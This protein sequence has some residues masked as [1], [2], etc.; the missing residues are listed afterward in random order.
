MAGQ[1]KHLMYDHTL[2]TLVKILQGILAGLLVL[3]LLTIRVWTGE[4]GS[5]EL[6]M[7]FERTDVFF[8]S[9]ENIVRRKIDYLQNKELFERGGSFDDTRAV[10]IRLYSS[11]TLD[12]ANLNVNT[13]YYLCDLLTFAQNG[14]DVMERRI[15][16]LLDQGLSDE[17]AGERPEAEAR[18]LETVLPVSGGT[19]ADYSYL[20]ANPG[21]VLRSYYRHLYETA[22]DVAYRYSQYQ[23][24]VEQEN[25]RN[26][27]QAPSNVLYYIENTGTKQ[28]YTNVSARSM[29]GARAAI[30]GEEGYVFLFEGDRRFNIMVAA[31]EH[32]LNEEASRYFLNQRFVGSGE[33]VLLAVNLDFPIGDELQEAYLYRS[34]IRPYAFA[35][36]T[37][38][39]ACAMLLPLL[40]ALSIV[41]TGKRE[42]GTLRPLDPFDQVQTEIAG[43]IIF[44]AGSSWWIAGQALA[45]GAASTRVRIV[46][47][48]FFA[49]TEYLI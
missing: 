16:T 39:V 48:A 46:L 28:R 14:A 3:C 13:S 33:R 42:N 5:G 23:E 26:A 7:S 45:S 38:A 4:N 37:L 34:E 10:D 8:R 47:T 21:I 30:Q 24:D 2:R 17:Q 49:G 11:G 18:T 6:G 19:L 41:M 32:I 22:Q 35:A 43:G 44:L 36:M 12:E 25:S 20:S 29:S 1:L 15:R 9:V 40:L 31:T 27:P